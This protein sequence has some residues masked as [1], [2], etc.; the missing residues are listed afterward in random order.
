[1]K[2]LNAYISR[3]LLPVVTFF[4][5]TGIWVVPVL[6]PVLFPD[7]SAQVIGLVA[8]ALFLVLH[9]FS[10]RSYV[11]IILTICSLVT[12]YIHG[13]NHMQPP[14]SEQHI[15]N[16]IEAKSEVIL[17][18]YLSEMV[19][20]DGKM[21]RAVVRIETVRKKEEDIHKPAH[22]KIRLS[23]RGEWPASILP[24]AHIVVRAQI[25][26]PRSYYVEGAF[27]YERFLAQRDIWVTGYVKSPLFIKKL[28]DNSYSPLQIIYLVERLRT[29]LGH[30]LDSSLPPKLSSLYRALLLGDKSRIPQENLELFK[31]TGTFHIL[32]VSGIHIAVIATF[33]YLLFYWLLSR[34]ERLLLHLNVR[35]LIA[36]ITLPLLLGYALL[37]GM[38]SPVLRAFLMSCIVI[39]AICSDR[40]KSPAPLVA[41]AALAIL[42]FDPVQLFTVSFQLSFAATIAI[43]FL[44]PHLQRMLRFSPHGGQVSLIQRVL[45]YIFSAFLVSVVATLATAPIIATSFNRISTIGPIANLIM[46]PLICLWCLPFGIIALPFTFISPQVADILLYCGSLGAR[47]A[48]NI[49]DMLASIPYA[50]LHIATPSSSFLLLYA[51]IFSGCISGLFLKRKKS[52]FVL[53]FFLPLI[54]A[55]MQRTSAPAEPTNPTISFLDV[56]QGSATVIQDGA[57]TIIIDGGG[58]SFSSRRV[59]E[60]VIAPYLW[61][62]GISTVETLIITH[63][64]A[65]HYNGLPYITTHFSPKTIWVRDIE[66]DDDLYK[67]FILK[68]EKSG[69]AVRIA[70]A[71][72]KLYD[73]NIQ[74]DCI[75]NLIVNR[76]TSGRGESGNSSLVLR[77]CVKETCFLFPGDINKSMEQYLLD[78]DRGVKADFYLAAHHGSITSNSLRFLQQVQS[79]YAI[80][81]AGTSPN[82]YFPHQSFLE[83]CETLDIQVLNTSID[84][85][86]EITLA[87]NRP[88]IRTTTKFRDNPLYPFRSEKLLYPPSKVHMEKPEER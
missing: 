87:K 31:A 35:K 63:P 47:I 14:A 12:G 64:D 86:I 42:V 22:G 84:G 83:K 88:Q 16:Q 29:H 18:G 34:S 39:L 24:G 57:H 68:T 21:S 27:D 30:Y 13:L 44:L 54:I 56:G 41:A 73:G 33:L 19:V 15:Y 85:T 67:D 80:V 32:A 74:L 8:V 4:F 20:Y 60:S 3:H 65:D 45:Y 55:L 69:V 7:S 82:G 28:A 77:G 23:F 9:L 10:R 58:S 48:L 25:K 79:E 37:A 61:N 6:S 81:S 53:L 50:S 40:A 36:V 46:E 51:C 72:D 43:L 17:T 38:N 2:D 78:H 59:G 1:M 76:P 62:K 70:K 52:I 26:R 11:P 49:A 71:G 75:E 66:G 5:I